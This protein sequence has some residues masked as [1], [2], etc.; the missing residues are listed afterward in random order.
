MDFYPNTALHS[1]I[2]YLVNAWHRSW[3][4]RVVPVCARFLVMQRVSSVKDVGEEGRGRR[5][6]GGRRC[7]GVSNEN[8]RTRARRP[9][10]GEWVGG[11]HTFWV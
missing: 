4:Q 10:Q 5:G 3:V 1:A 6:L 7:V 2:A 9:A 11:T 8:E